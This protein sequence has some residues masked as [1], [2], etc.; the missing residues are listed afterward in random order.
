MVAHCRYVV[1]GGGVVPQ[2]RRCG[3][4]GVAAARAAS[5]GERE[6]GESKLRT[7]FALARQAEPIDTADERIQQAGKGAAKSAD[8]GVDPAR[9]D[10]TPTRVGNTRQLGIATLKLP[11]EMPLKIGVGPPNG[12]TLFKGVGVRVAV[13]RRRGMAH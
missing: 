4:S 5:N 10:L 1:D 6:R 9:P 2:R 12:D 8:P 7:A 11:A 13:S 3:T